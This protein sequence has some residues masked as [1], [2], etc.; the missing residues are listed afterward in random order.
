MISQLETEK[1]ARQA[2]VTKARDQVSEIAQQ[3]GGDGALSPALKSALD[4]LR[5]QP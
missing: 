2:V 5:S 3:P 4:S 1:A